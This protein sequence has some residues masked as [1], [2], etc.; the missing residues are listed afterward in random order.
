M[1]IVLKTGYG[2]IKGNEREFCNEFLGIRYARAERFEYATPVD[3]T[4]EKEYD[5]TAFGNVCPQT[6]TYYEHLEVPERLFYHNEFRKNIIY[7]YDEDC[8]NLNI[9]T[10]KN[11]ENAPVI[12]FIH[13]GGFNSGSVKDSCFDGECYAKRGCILVTFNYRVGVLGYLTHKD[14]FDKYNREGNFGLDDQLLAIKWVKRHIKDFGGNPDNITL[15]GQSAGAI[16]IQ[17]L[18][19]SHQNEGL[20]QHAFMMS[21]GGLFPK[22]ALPRNA[23]STREYWLNFMDIAGCKSLD[24]LKK[25]D[26]HSLFTAIEEIKKI[27]KDNTYNTMPVVDGYL[28]PEPIEKMIADPIKI[29]YVIGYTNNDMYAAIMAHI[30]NKFAKD[31]NGY[32]LFF[33]IDAPGT[34]K[35]GAF[36]SSELRYMFDTLG[37]SH[38]PYTERDKEVSHMLID[39]IVEFAKCGNPNGDGRPFW[40]SKPG[41]ALCVGK[42]NIKMGRPN[43]LKLLWNT[44][45]KGDPK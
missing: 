23:E 16:S 26:L 29:D 12:I 34:D 45:T 7:N 25:L 17:Y 41:Y 39:Y 44:L 31:N 38:R 14:I 15:M 6:R 22:F 5:A 10:P 32:V 24:E 35:N 18:C 9:Y 28:I 36:H 40:I 43:S 4:D 1:S 3:Q 11:A 2:L 8:L 21:G 37:S 27:R 13:G 30:G 19:L 42:K 20:F 33:D